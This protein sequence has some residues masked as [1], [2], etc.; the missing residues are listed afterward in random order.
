MQP[1]PGVL[2]FRSKLPYTFKCIYTKLCL[3]ADS[4]EAIRS[5][6]KEED[7]PFVKPE[8]H[9]LSEEAAKAE[10]RVLDYIKHLSGNQ[11]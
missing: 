7:E 4:N 10:D 11:I 2:A 3:K 9:G 8:L 6:S 1:R 5:E